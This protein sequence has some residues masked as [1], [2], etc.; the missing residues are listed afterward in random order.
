MLEKKANISREY[1]LGKSKKDILNEL[2]DEFNF[3]P[4]NIWTYT[5]KK[6]WYGKKKILF[7]YFEKECIIKI[8]IRNCWSK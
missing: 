4:N 1:L 7:L 5:L 3:Y 8:Y 2:G 6:C